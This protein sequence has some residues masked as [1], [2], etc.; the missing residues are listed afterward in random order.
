MKFQVTFGG[1][2]SPVIVGSIMAVMTVEAPSE[3]PVQGGMSNVFPSR[4]TIASEE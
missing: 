4:S 1:L 2:N 3:V